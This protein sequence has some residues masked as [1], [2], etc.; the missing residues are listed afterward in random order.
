MGAGSDPKLFE[1]WGSRL[2]GWERIFALET[3]YK[4]TSS[5]VGYHAEFGRSRS[6]GLD[7]GLSR[8]FQKIG[9][10]RCPPLR[11]HGVTD[12]LKTRPSPHGLACRICRCQTICL[13]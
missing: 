13:S 8:E 7:I 5:H 2:L 11:M 12:P 3:P 9:R 6:N 1:L 4:H 10:A